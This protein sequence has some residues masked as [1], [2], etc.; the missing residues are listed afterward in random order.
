M[1]FA[2]LKVQYDALCR[3]IAEHEHAYYVL[4]QPKLSDQAFD[5]LYRQLVDFESDHPDLKSPDSPTQRVGGQPLEGFTSVRHQVPMMS[6]DNTYSQDEVRD[7]VNRVS[8]LLP[9]ETLD[10][11]VEPKVDG[12]ALSLRYEQGRLA[13]GTTRGDGIQ[14]DDITANIRTIRSVPLTL[15]TGD[16]SPPERLEV[17]GEVFMTKEG[18]A[19]LNAERREAGEPSFV[20][21]RNSA[22]GSLKQLDP[23]LVAARPLDI[24]VYAIARFQATAQPSPASQLDSL[25]CLRQFGFKTPDRI[26]HCHSADDLLRVIEEL[27]HLKHSFAYETD[28]AVIKLNRIALHQRVGATAKAPRWAMAFK[29]AAEQAETIL[30]AIT[31]Q[32]GRTGA[33]TPVAELEPVFVGGTTVSR[34]TLHNEEELRRKDIRIGDT[35]VVEKAGEI[36]P[37]VVRVVMDQRQPDAAPFEFPGVCPE[38]QTP[39]TREEGQKAGGVVIRCENPDCP[40]QV[41]ER[42]EHWC[43]RG[44]MDIE[45]GGQVLIQKLV[46]RGLASNLA[47]LYQLKLEEV[48][49]LERM[50][51]K[52]AQNFLDGLEASK[53]RDLWRLVFGLGILHVGA[54]VAKTLGRNYPDLFQLMDATEDQLVAIDEIGEVIAAS[55]V[56]WF[57]EPAHQE[58]IAKLERAGLNFKSALYQP[59]MTSGPC[60]GQIFVLTGTLPT[61]TRSEASA[62]IE[63]AGGKVSS[64]VSKKTD[65]VV[66]G[67]EAGSKLEKAKKLDL[68]ILSEDEFLDLIRQEPDSAPSR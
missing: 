8:K 5:R 25:E 44:A 21:P 27:G 49:A 41:R 50:A 6:L 33:L 28:G 66:A 38:C 17:R 20:N 15:A 12:V 43:S 26:W 11:T 63:K 23:Q 42:L 51:E 18:F 2:D 64:S 57:G 34:A 7:F 48:A 62:K 16:A 4:A 45:G 13:L 36:I 9:E 24:I 46:E 30:S 54:G 1:S 39:V 65:F 59:E 60:S 55:L 53:Q 61:L 58:L 19:K 52:S 67:T 35:V 32:V 37:A 14:G 22:A 31:I 10:W 56:N 40:A 3:E 47:E 68:R 29:Y